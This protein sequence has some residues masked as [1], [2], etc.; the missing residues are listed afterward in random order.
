M[1]APGPSLLWISS[2]T[3]W[4]Y[5]DPCLSRPPAH[6]QAIAVD[7]AA[8]SRAN[9]SWLV[10]VASL[11]SP[12]HS[13]GN[14]YLSFAGGNQ[15]GSSQSGCSATTLSDAAGAGARSLKFQDPDLL[16]GHVCT[17]HDNIEAAM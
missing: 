14:T 4:A 15:P 6:T 11:L 16:L 13:S 8:V 2:A 12:G 10:G 7:D 3:S 5:S 9:S 17:F 1:R